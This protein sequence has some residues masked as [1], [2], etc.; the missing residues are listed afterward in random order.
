M[1]GARPPALRRPVPPEPPVSMS[2]RR[3]SQELVHWLEAGAG[4][5]GIRLAA[6]LA[7]GLVLSLLVA[8]KQFHGPAGEATLLQADLARQL[9]RGAGF[10]TQVN[11]PQSAA[12]LA[13][14]GRSFDPHRPFPELSQAPLYALVLGGGLRLLPASF[15]ASLFT[16]PPSDAFGGDY[17]LLGV[18]L[19]LF[20]LAA[21]LTWDLGR[22]LFA[23]RVAWLALLAFF[24][25]VSAWQQVLAVN[26]SPLLMVLVLA[27]F[28]VWLDLD[29]RIDT[30]A[31]PG[32]FR[33]AALG[34][35]CGLLFLAEYSA[36]A[37]VLVA[38]GYAL[39]RL[40]GPA[41]F[42]TVA[43]LLA[44]FAAFA[45]PWGVRNVLLTGSPTALAA[46]N[47]ALKAGDPTAEP[48]TYRTRL[49]PAGPRIDLNKLA[50]KVLTQL[51][52]NVRSR[53]WSGGGL[54]LTAFFVAGWLYVFRHPTA[55]RLRWT[56]TIALGV[57]VLS[58]AVFNSGE[59]ER[60]AILWL[61]PLIIVFGAGFFFVLLD[62]S[63]AVA[64]WPRLAAGALVC[65]QAL[66]L[67]RDVLEPPPP[68]RFNYPPYYPPLLLG[69]RLE[70]EQ[71][72]ALNSFGVMADIPAGAAWYGDQRV[73]AQP[74]RLKDFYSIGVDQP[75]AELLLTPVTLDRPFFSELALRGPVAGSV[76]SVTEKFG[77][78]GQVYSAFLTG[79][80][81]PEFPL[82]VPQKLSDNLY[83]LFN[84]ALPRPRGK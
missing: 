59:S 64:A 44:A 55:N 67:L 77:E 35:L 21:A 41:R 33:P 74:A 72:G 56:F 14:R 16:R 82:T 52:E 84:P 60:L 57:L 49:S 83:V 23:P 7:G 27:A 38:V 61:A 2:R 43:L 39:W 40:R 69:L 19:V 8:W 48:A 11:Y 75:I 46:Q 34:A 30:G 3:T 13:Q 4:A 9:A 70:L 28:E 12:L 79:R 36:G 78:W 32:L 26:G 80:V 63:P 31:A 18:N 42:A 51:Q 66:P 25:S 5:R 22:R 65:L 15:R 73:W 81:P 45:V 37:L 29:R 76:G 47:I 71:R 53:L 6:V 62:A 24:L 50:N 54:F 68:I 17:F 10:T 20:W 1:P 58:Q